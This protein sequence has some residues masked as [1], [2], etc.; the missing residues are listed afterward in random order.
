MTNLT[1]PQEYIVGARSF[2]DMAINSGCH[3]TDVIR[4]KI[5]IRR[6]AAAKHRPATDSPRAQHRNP[7]I[8]FRAVFCPYFKAGP[9]GAQQC[10]PIMRSG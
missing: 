1:Y 8:I 5:P 6:P 3:I 7:C 10:N 2:R 9:R 4:S